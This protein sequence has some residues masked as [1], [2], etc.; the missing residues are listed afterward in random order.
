MCG[1]AVI[2]SEKPLRKDDLSL[3]KSMI[4][5]FI[6]RGPDSQGVYNDSN[7]ALGIRRLMII[8]A[9]KAD[10]PL[11]NEDDSLVLVVN[12]EIY[13]YLELRKEL[14]NKGHQFKTDGDGE[15]ILHL[16]ED[17]QEDCVHKLRGM[18]A[19]A[20]YDKKRRE[21]FIARDKMGEKPLYYH[22]N[23][24]QF[25]FSSEMKSILL[26][27]RPAGLEIDPD[28]VNMYFHYQYVPE[29]LTCVKGIRKLPAAH[30]IKLNLNDFSFKLQKYWD[31]GDV[32]PVLGNPVD[33]VRESFDELSKY[34]IRA[35]VPVGVSLSGGLDSSAIACSVAK[36]CKDQMQAFSVGYPGHPIYDERRSAKSLADSLGMRFHEVELRTDQLVDSFQ[37]LVYGLDDPIADVAAFGYYSVCRLAKE[38]NVP[39]LL[40]GFGGDE[41]FWGYEWARKSV[42]RNLLKK[43][44]QNGS[45]LPP[46]LFSEFANIYEDIG[47]RN[48]C[49]HPISSTRKY[50]SE[51]KAI[52]KKLTTHF[53]RFIL[54][55]ENPDFK[56]AYNYK[57]LLYSKDFTENVHK[58]MLYDSFTTGDWESIPFQTCCFLLQPWNGSN[59]VVL[60]DRTSMAFSVE[61]RLPFLDYKFV[62]LVMGLRKTY[63]NDYKLGNKAWFREAM[64][65]LV[66]CNIISFV[67]IKSM[68]CW[69][70]LN[71]GGCH[72]AEISS[73]INQRGAQRA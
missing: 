33:I 26:Y 38:N 29:P 41:L 30:F 40:F 43:E 60:G 57:S 70:Q 65:D 31:V 36:H 8:D 15:T 20:L 53:D 25:V 45:K 35:D 7:V 4:Q 5:Q 42:T 71:Q 34:I 49:M 16:Y 12:G 6:H 44:L 73:N 39:V 18:F 28:A 59:N 61:S 10:Q 23:E 22:Q 24:K 68:I 17:Y 9:E 3:F 50:L 66:P 13:N 21:I 51:M 63:S 56:A 19:F 32:K 37:E 55:D 11:F 67:Y 1:I 54:W 27:L 69:R 64:K 52:R 46:L 47:K 2:V 72:V 58:E 14:A 48:L 62:E